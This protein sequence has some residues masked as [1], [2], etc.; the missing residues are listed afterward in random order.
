MSNTFEEQL[1]NLEQLVAIDNPSESYK[2]YF[3]KY[4]RLPSNPFPPSGIADASGDSP[5]LQDEVV[6]KI[7][8]FI[9]QTY[10]SRKRQFLVLRGDYGTGKTHTLHFIE[11]VINSRM[12]KGDRA[13]R[14][15]YVE[16]P[17]IEA[18]EL[19]RTILRSLGYDTV[20]KYIWFA[21]HRLL[22]EEIATESAPI[23]ELVRSLSVPKTK[24]NLPGRKMLWDDS[25]M[26]QPPFSEI[27]GAR[28]I[29]DHR[30]FFFELE[31]NGWSRE[32]LRPYLGNLLL[33]A[34][35]GERPTELAQLFIGLLLAPDDNSFTSWETILGITNSRATSSLRAPTFL[36][37]LLR[38]LELNGIVYV[39]LL[40]DE[41]EEVSQGSLLTARQRQDYLYTIR[42]LLNSVPTGLSIIIGISF[43]GWDAIVSIATPLADVNDLLVDLKRI[44]TS[45]VIKLVQYYFAR[46]R[47]STEFEDVE[48]I[49]PFTNEDLDYIVDNMPRS[50]Q[51]TPRNIIQ[52][53]HSLMNYL[54]DNNIENID[55]LVLD[56][57]LSD[58]GSI[59]SQGSRLTS[60]R[61]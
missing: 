37:F 44:S 6:V 14:A 8:N 25:I 46:E 22:A 15:I 60:G 20:R 40:L 49:A 45:D 51:A 12:N 56:H 47:R 23:K 31:R 24:K 1:D 42:E 5:P 35:G 7:I 27:F 53:L 30:N 29:S 52:F 32:E 11:Y 16:R 26:S 33:E 54:A 48:G 58:F 55:K 2:H 4:F 38:L 34:I 21:I 10:S 13:A 17:R 50:I 59:K 36:K 3:E 41:F 28:S 61:R 43:P 57:M 18:Q 39:Y 9:R 19:N